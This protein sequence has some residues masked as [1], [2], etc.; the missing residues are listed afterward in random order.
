MTGKWEKGKDAQTLLAMDVD[1]DDDQDVFG[2][3]EDLES[4]KM[5]QGESLLAFHSPGKSENVRKIAMMIA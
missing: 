5:F 4:G 2:D 1:E 3:F